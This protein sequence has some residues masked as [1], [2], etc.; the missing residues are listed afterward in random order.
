[1]TFW[2][3]LFLCAKELLSGAREVETKPALAS[4]WL[5]SATGACCLP[6]PAAALSGRRR[7]APSARCAL[8]A[9][10]DLADLSESPD[11]ALSASRRSASLLSPEALARGRCLALVG[12]AGR[13]LPVTIGHVAAMRGVVDPGIAL[14]AGAVEAIE[15]VDVDVDR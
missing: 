2:Q 5:Q 11:L 12:K 7:G 1:M 8:R 4:C 14:D 15:A 6:P 13:H 10:F 9:L 3:V